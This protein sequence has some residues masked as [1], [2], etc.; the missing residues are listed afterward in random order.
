MAVELNI[1]IRIEIGK[2]SSLSG[3]PCIAIDRGEL[4]P[5]G[6]CLVWMM[7]RFKGRDLPQLD[8]SLLLITRPAWN[9]NWMKILN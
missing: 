3:G 5:R 7:I 9:S 2:S 8:L 4:S 6:N 1:L